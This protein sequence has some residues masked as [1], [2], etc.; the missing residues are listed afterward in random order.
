M[1]DRYALE[2]NTAGTAVFYK[3]A[4]FGAEDDQPRNV[5]TTLV[6]DRIILSDLRIEDGQIVLEM[7]AHGPGDADC[8]PTHNQRVIYALGEGELS[9]VAEETLAEAE[10]AGIFTPDADP[11]VV[12]LAL[13]A[14]RSSSSTRLWSASIAA[15][16]A[17]AA[18]TL[19]PFLR[20]GDFPLAYM[21]SLDCA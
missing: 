2:T 5:A 7:I 18:M 11:T 17:G 14:M 6:G 19:L 10:P 12:T 15:A 21:G 13:G 8:Y 3:L 1:Y 9:I 4:V 20:I 16:M